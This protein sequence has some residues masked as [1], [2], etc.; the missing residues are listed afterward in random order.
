MTD[1]DTQQLEIQ[2][3]Q[4]DNDRSPQET[5][6]WSTTGPIPGPPG[7]AGNRNKVA[8]TACRWPTVGEG[9]FGLDI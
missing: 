7:H 8:T 2:S 9:E 4:V 6:D 5:D 3:D 1:R